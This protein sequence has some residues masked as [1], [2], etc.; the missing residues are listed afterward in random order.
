M[1]YS[2]DNARTGRI[3]L[4]DLVRAVA[5]VGIALVNV[6]Y[7]AYPPDIT[8]H[9]GGLNNN[10]D[11]LTYF[12]VNSFFLFKSYTLFSFMFGVGLA[13]QMLSAQRRNVSFAAGYFRRM[14]A[15]IILGVL[16]VTVA[17]IGDI[18]I[19]YG[20]L[21]VM[22]YLFRQCSQKTL[23]R[24]GIAMIVL[25]V[26]IALVFAA[27]LY[28][29]EFYTPDE[30]TGLT[31]EMQQYRE[32]AK[33]AYSAGS[34]IEVAAQRWTDWVGMITTAAPLQ[35]PGA[36]GFFLIGLAAARAGVLSN[37]DAPLWAQA[38]RI[39]LPVGIV[40]SMLGA[41][42]ILRS[43]GE[44]SYTTM[45]GYALLLLAAPLSSLGYIG[46]IARWA[47]GPLTPLKAFIARGGTAS[48]TAYLLQSI[49]MSL[50]F[51]GYGL[52]LYAKPGAAA[53]IFIALLT[54]VLSVVFTSLW[55]L[56]YQR[57]PMELVL[58]QW[59]YLAR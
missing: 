5:L 52:G 48:L 35:I 26:F 16:H 22:L 27:A 8:Y 32:V 38:R 11:I 50:L 39:Y 49:V 7:F 12:S 31:N 58:R 9:D 1:S 33:Q 19:I 59:T 41:L 20:V 4:P 46:I 51:C 25:Q 53:C 42:V 21:G 13:H 43:D 3:V 57:G 55:R 17:F 56:R 18:L 44:L 29:T 6:A 30:W 28:F 15:L 34:F 47:R 40:L 45:L 24:T 36:F 54:G 2:E 10:A 37:P 14:L 23:I